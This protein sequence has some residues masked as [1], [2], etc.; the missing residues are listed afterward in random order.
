M[1]IPSKFKEV[2]LGKLH[3]FIQEYPLGTLIFSAENTLDADHIPFYLQRQENEQVIL[4]SHI[5]KA[6]PLWKKVVDG[7]EALLIF[8]GPN[9]YISPNLYPSKKETGKAVPTWNYS[10]VH[11]RGRVFFKHES[12]W[13][14]QLLNK[15]SD[16]HELNQNLPWSVSDAPAEFTK[17]LVNAVVGLEVVID[18]IVGNFK[19]SQNKTASDYSGVVNGL[20]SSKNSSDISVARQMQQSTCS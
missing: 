11:V 19:L 17:K 2:N 18:D 8:H 6:N 1:H 7:Q 14:L 4:Q 9:A 10:V 20:A 3:S 12:N 5:A 15:I 16:F 13:I